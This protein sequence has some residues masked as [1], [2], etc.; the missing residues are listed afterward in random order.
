MPRTHVSHAPLHC[1]AEIGVCA[2]TSAVD[3]VNVSLSITAE[4]AVAWIRRLATIAIRAM[5]DMP[6][7]GAEVKGGAIRSLADRS[8]K[9]LLAG[10]RGLR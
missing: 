5:H 4:P 2:A 1:L 10:V 9:I 8:A 7:I 6:E 3:R